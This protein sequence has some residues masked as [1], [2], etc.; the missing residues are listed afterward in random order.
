MLALALNTS[1]AVSPSFIPE[2]EKLP[3][4]RNSS[5]ANAFVEASSSRFWAPSARFDFVTA[6][7][8][9]A[10]TAQPFLP[11]REFHLSGIASLLAK[12]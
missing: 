3:C 8:A 5:V 12:I 6:T 1:C 2:V 9:G 10:P 4:Q 7:F 11:M